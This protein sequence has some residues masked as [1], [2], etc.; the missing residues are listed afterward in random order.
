MTASGASWQKRWHYT[1]ISGHCWIVGFRN[2]DSGEA[3]RL[4]RK[5]A[6][7]HSGIKRGKGRGLPTVCQANL[8]PHTAA[9]FSCR[10]GIR[11]Q[12]SF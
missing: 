5:E 11:N 3:E 6:E 4:F 2:G 12:N 10:A 8:L 7:R 1:R 9:L